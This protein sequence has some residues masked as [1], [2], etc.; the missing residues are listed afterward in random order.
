MQPGTLSQP[1]RSF[2]QF[3]KWLAPEGEMERSP[4]ATMPR[5]RWLLVAAGS[6]GGIPRSRNA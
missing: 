2:Q 3:F 5:A 4:M 1:F 6:S